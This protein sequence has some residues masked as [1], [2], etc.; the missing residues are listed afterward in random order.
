MRLFHNIEE[1]LFYAI[2]CFIEQK[3]L[4]KKKRKKKKEGGKKAKNKRDP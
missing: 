3:N 2:E 4:K 1:Y